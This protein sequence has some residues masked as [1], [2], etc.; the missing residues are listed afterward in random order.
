MSPTNVR[1]AM[2]D[3]NVV[4]SACTGINV[5]NLGKKVQVRTKV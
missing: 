1:Y 2:L 5:A 3:A 4:I